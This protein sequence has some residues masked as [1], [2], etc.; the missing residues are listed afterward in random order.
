MIIKLHKKSSFL[1]YQEEMMK[2]IKKL[3]AV[4]ILALC[5]VNY[6]IVNASEHDHSFEGHR[7]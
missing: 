3:L 2:H 4:S 6:S 1:C 5:S 7:C